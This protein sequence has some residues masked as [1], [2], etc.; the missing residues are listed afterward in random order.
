LLVRPAGPVFLFLQGAM[1]LSGDERYTSV[2]QR[3]RVEVEIKKSRFIGDIAPVPDE[4]AALAFIDAVRAEFPTATHHC[5]AYITG[6]PGRVVR[7]NDDG[8]P[9]G[10]AGRPIL[11][12]IEREGLTNTVV[13]VTRY[14]GGTLLGAAGLVR[15]YAGTAS[16]AVAAAGVVEYVL[17]ERWQLRCDYAHWGKLEF[18]LRTE[19]IKVGDPR[20]GTAV[21]VELAVPRRQAAALRQSIDDLLSGTAKWREM[22]P[23]FLPA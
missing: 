12:V 20:F 10:T 19:E 7:M 16:Q 11:E 5:Y 13:V 18:Y 14:F 23:A 15:A 17:H 2:R 3:A 8:E 21:E 9:S 22:S 4:S 1:E 6:Y